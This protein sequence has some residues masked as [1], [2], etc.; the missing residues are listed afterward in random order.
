MGHVQCLSLLFSKVIM[1]VQPFGRLLFQA[2]PNALDFG[3]VVLFF[4]LCFDF[5][6]WL[7]VAGTLFLFCVG[8]APFNLQAHLYYLPGVLYVLFPFTLFRYVWFLCF[9]ILSTYHAA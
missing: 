5:H 8:H 2:R 4:K 7:S 3:L 6:Y 1:S 9:F